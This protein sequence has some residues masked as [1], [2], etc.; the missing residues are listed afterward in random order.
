MAAS[1]SLIAKF[2]QKLAKKLSKKI[3]KKA[4]SLLIILAWGD[5]STRLTILAIAL[6]GEASKVMAVYYSVK[7]CFGCNVY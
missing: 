7:M 4:P 2:Q 1:L 6:L 3:R 5:A